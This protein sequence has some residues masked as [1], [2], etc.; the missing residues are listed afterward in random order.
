MFSDVLSWLLS[1]SSSTLS[2]CHF[3]R[4]GIHNRLLRHLGTIVEATSNNVQGFAAGAFIY[5]IGYTCILLLVEVIIADTTSL[6]SRL[7]FSYVPTAPFIIN[8]WVSGEISGAVLAN[9]TWRWG[10]G[11]WCIIY[12]VCALPLIISLWWVGRKA[13][14]SGSLNDYRTPLQIYGPRRLAVGLFWQLDVI[15]IILLIAVFGLILVPLTLAG[16]YSSKWADG[17]IIAPIVIGLV[18]IP[19]WIMWEKRAPHPM[20]P[21]HVSL[22]QSHQS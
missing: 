16:G 3:T 9:S 12:P 15:G 19:A 22:T 17:S 1:P 20:V 8:T 18:C 7:F 2:V 14:K 6:R 10:V 13:K 5:Q 4:F 21:F 11:M